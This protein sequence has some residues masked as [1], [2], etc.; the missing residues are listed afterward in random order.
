MKKII[1]TVVFLMA[2]L[3]SCTNSRPQLNYNTYIEAADP[4]SADYSDQ[5]SKVGEMQSSFGSVNIRYSKSATPDLTSKYDWKG[6][7]W[8]GEKKSAM[9][10]IWTPENLKQVECVFSSFK[11]DNGKILD[12]QIAKAQFVRYTLTD[13][14]GEGCAER[15]HLTPSLAADVLDTIPGIDMEAKTTRPVW[16]SFNIPSEAEAGIYK[17]VVEIYVEGTKK[18]ELD[19]T[20]KVLD[21]TLPSPKDWQ[22]HL[23]LWQ[24]PTSVARINNVEV[25]SEEHWELMKTPMKMLADA[26]QKVITA[27]LNKDPWNHQCYDGYEDMILWTRKMDGSWQYDYKI[28]DRWVQFMMDLG[29]KNYINCYS[30]APWNNEIHYFDEKEGKMIDVSAK[31]GTKEF[32]DLWY[33]FLQN[34]KTHLQE[35]GWLEITNIAMDERSPEIMNATLKLL[36]NAAPEL[37]VALA[38]NHKSYKQY[39]WLRD[40]CVEYGAEFDN[41]DLKYRRENGLISTFYTYCGT[42]FPNAFT[43]SDPAEC[44]FISW[45]A[46]AAGY[47][48]FLRWAYNSWNENPLHDSRYKTWSAGDAFIIYPAGRSSIRFERLIE[49]IQD[50]EKIRILKDEFA[51]NGENEKLN[52]LLEELNKFNFLGKPNRPCSEM[53]DE[54]KRVLDSLSEEA[55]KS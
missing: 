15:S 52:V 17:G 5:W 2:F 45:H 48:G 53:V 26:G 3:F 13:S 37:G 22:Y 25:W 21:R 31:P 11:G 49:G 38:D 46:M 18:K 40:I 32:R 14:Y 47:D 44:V 28:F 41:A 42:E 8:K 6:T 30:L 36:K 4:D 29:I 20:L 51:K 33:P 55:P 35:K 23:D 34:F 19:I 54:A 43:F 7:I 1:I 12:S 39:P 50:F 24:H 27:T 16:L 10:V 9:L